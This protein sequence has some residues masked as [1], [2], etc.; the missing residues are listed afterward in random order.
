MTATLLATKRVEKPWGRHHL[1]PG[2][3]DPAPGAPAVGEV[4]FQT[5]HADAPEL[6][7]K[8]LFTS[9]RL[10]VAG[11]SDRRRGAGARAQARQG[12]MLGDPG[13]RTRCDHRARHAGADDRRR[14][15]Q[16]FRGRIDR[17]QARLETCEGGGI[18]L[19]GRGDDPCDWRGDHAGRDATECRSDVPALRLRIGP[20]TPSEGWRRGRRCRTLRRAVDAGQSL[21]RPNH[22]RRRAEVRPRT[23]AGRDAAGVVARG[24]AGLAGAPHRRRCRGRRRL[25]GG[26]MRAGRGGRGSGFRGG[27][28]TC[29]SRIRG[30]RESSIGLNRFC[31]MAGAMLRVLT[32]STL[33]PRRDATQLRRVRRAADAWA[34]GASGCR[35]D[36]GGA[37]RTAAPAAFTTFAVS[38]ACRFAD[39][40][41]LEG[42]RRSP[43]AICGSAG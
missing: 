34:G 38:R 22:P 4:W 25:C 12:R 24:Q 26:R 43:P 28:A 31:P 41:D 11:P 1:W 23:L 7:I 20:R 3:A 39:A 17:R 36:R 35:A 2:F 10:S 42:P 16:G 13:R 21:R 6:L 14:I 19:F 5:P 33:F 18:L 15:A 32:L 9:E 8:Y 29:C 40:R 27:A 30:R 37:G